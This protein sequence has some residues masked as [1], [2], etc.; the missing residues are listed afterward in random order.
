M[1]DLLRFSL[2]KDYSFVSKA[3]NLRFF[4]DFAHGVRKYDD[5]FMTGPKTT[6][7]YAQN[8]RSEE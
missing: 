6:G 5:S 4:L 8:T 3:Q 1:A 7:D 2:L